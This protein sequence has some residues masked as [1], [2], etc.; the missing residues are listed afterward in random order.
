VLQP[1]D[2]RRMR[3]S[4]AAYPIAAGELVHRRALRRGRSRRQACNERCHRP[5]PGR[6]RRP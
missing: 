3:D 2:V 6:Q 1:D 5:G 4:V